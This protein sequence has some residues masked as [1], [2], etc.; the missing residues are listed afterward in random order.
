MTQKPILVYGYPV[1]GD[2]L[3]DPGFG[4]PGGGGP[5][6]P[7]FGKPS[8]PPHLGGGPIPAP[9]PG[10]AV[11][12]IHIPP[13][14]VAV[15]PIFIPDH[16]DN[17]LPAAPGIIWPPLPPDAGISGKVLLLIWVVGVGYRWLVYEAPVIWPP[18]AVPGHPL[19]NPPRP[20]P[21]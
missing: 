14:G 1:E 15:P 11:P 13:G 10:I 2:G 6:D 12:P 21:K 4:R 19:P 9:P 3:V 8:L 7:G 18:D 17:T 16:P 20:Q 5:V